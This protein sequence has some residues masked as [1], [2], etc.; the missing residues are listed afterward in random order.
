MDKQYPRGG[1]FAKCPFSD[2]WQ[3]SGYAC[4]IS[5]IYSDKLVDNLLKSTLSTSKMS[6]TQGLA[7]PSNYSIW[8]LL[9]SNLHPYSQ[10]SDLG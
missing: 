8:Y 3:G 5:N 10:S 7:C 9:F 1:S 2:A 4:V 6:V